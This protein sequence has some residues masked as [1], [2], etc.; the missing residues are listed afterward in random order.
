M[1][2]SY[3]K[4]TGTTAGT[5]M[6]IV[7]FAIFFSIYLYMTNAQVQST[8]QLNLES[9]SLMKLKSTFSLFNASLGNT[10]FISTVQ[11]IFITGDESIG[12][13]ID[14]SNRL[15]EDYWYWRDPNQGRDGLTDSQGRPIERIPATNKGN[16]WGRNPQVCYPRDNHVLTYLQNKL[17]CDGLLNLKTPIDTGGVA[18]VFDS[19]RSACNG[20]SKAVSNFLLNL[21]DDNIESKFSQSITATYGDGRIVAQTENYNKIMTSFR[22]MVAKGRQAIEGLLLFGD[23]LE[24]HNPQLQYSQSYANKDGYENRIKSFLNTIF[25]A[26]VPSGVL[27]TT[28]IQTDMRAADSTVSGVMHNGIGLVVHYKAKATYTEGATQVSNTLFPWPTNSRKLNSCY[29]FRKLDENDPG[30]FHMGIDIVP[31]VD[32]VNAVGDGVV[33][34]TYNDCPVGALGSLC[35]GP[36]NQGYGNMIL[37]KHS[38]YYSFYAH[39]RKDSITVA[40]GDSVGTGQQIALMGSSGSSTGV[41]L[42]FELRTQATAGS[43]VNPCTLIDCTQSSDK[44]CDTIS[45]PTQSTPG[46]YYYNDENANAFVKRPI[47]L[48]YLAEDYMPALDCTAPPQSNLPAR[49]IY[50]NWQSSNDMMCCAGNLFSC[51]ADIPGLDSLQ[52]LSSGMSIQ[53]SIPIQSICNGILSGS[54]LSCT[55]AGFQL[56]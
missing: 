35:G 24:Q 7:I 1:K 30:K 44:K 36:G 33:V 41:H 20:N 56:S 11:A 22:Q 16:D 48:E 39:L 3:S 49:P 38:N 18:I 27:A 29:G 55:S 47:R 14:T 46:V 53:D 17:E 51:N 12:C 34:D 15:T 25:T 23:S 37:I 6:L 4:G 9:L 42:H 2:N 21:N 13:G 40:K 26:R 5:I 8:I 10:W 45:T 54:T 28:D 50:F 52:K 19:V 43:A 32:E 31:A